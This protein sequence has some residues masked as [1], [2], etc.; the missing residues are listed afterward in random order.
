MDTLKLFF[1]IVASKFYNNINSNYNFV[2]DI[3]KKDKLHSN[4]VVSRCTTQ[5]HIRTELLSKNSLA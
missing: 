5:I 1:S 2:Y 3:A 4:G